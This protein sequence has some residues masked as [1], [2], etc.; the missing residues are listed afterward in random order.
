[1]DRVET[2]PEEAKQSIEQNAAAIKA[3]EA[4]AEAP[5]VEAKPT[6]EAPKD[7]KVPDAPKP[8]AVPEDVEM[9]AEQ[10]AKYSKE[11]SAG[12]K[13]SDESYAELAKQGIPKNIVDSYVQGQMALV[14]QAQQEVFTAVGGADSYKAMVDWAASNLSS[15]EVAAYNNAVESGNKSQ[16]MFA[17]KG[18]QARFA[19]Q[20]EPRLLTGD[21]GKVA[22]GFRSSAEM[23]EAMKD[24]KYKSDPAYRADVERRMS[25][26]N[27]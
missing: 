25:V 27:F 12:G 16:I 6:G 3:A 5:P 9:S 11:L 1:M 23:I 26:S 19:A 7:L 22:R 14:Q 2:N 15:D 13:L 17:V 8:P 10:F 18:L 4:V 24:P 20:S 21:G